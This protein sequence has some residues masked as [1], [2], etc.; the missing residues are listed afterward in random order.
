M[1]TVIS[2]SKIPLTEVCDV[3]L[4]LACSSSRPLPL[5][6]SSR[7]DWVARGAQVGSLTDLRRATIA[8]KPAGR[9][10]IGVIAL[11]LSDTETLFFNLTSKS[12]AAPDELYELSNRPSLPT[13]QPP[14]LAK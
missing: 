2:F 6:T 3:L 4:A 5:T 12:V 1:P 8:A 14:F 9:Y 11:S 10:L 7:S 13:C